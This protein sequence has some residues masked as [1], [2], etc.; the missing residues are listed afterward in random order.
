MPATK[1][2]AVRNAAAIVCGN[3]AQTRRVGE[4]LGDARSSRPGRS[5]VVDRADRVLHPRVGGEDEVRGEVGAERDE[6]DRREVD[7]LGQ[8]VPAEDPQAEER[9]LEEE[10]RQGLHRERR[11]E[12]V[13]DEPRVL[14]PVHA[15]LE[16][17][18]D[19]GGHADGEVDQ[20]QL[21]EELGQA[22]PALVARPVPGGL[23]D[24]DERRE[25]DRQRHED[26]VVDRRDAELPSGQGKCVHSVSSGRGQS[27]RDVAL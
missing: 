26:E 23:H 12:D 9:R 20:H 10:G 15:E 6:P 16:L 5:R 7:L 11:A 27:G 21:A 1:V 19:A 24:R 13:A 25:A 4:H 18:H 22:E 14:A 8:L 17:L 2:P 3:A